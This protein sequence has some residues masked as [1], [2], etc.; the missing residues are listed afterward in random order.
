[1]ARTPSHSHALAQALPRS[2][3]FALLRPATKPQLDATRILTI[4][5]TLAINLIALGV[6]MMPLA[7]PTPA[8]WEEPAPR[9]PVRDIPK[10]K[11]VVVEIVEKAKPVPVVQPVRPQTV[12]PA[13]NP[14]NNVV[15]ISQTGSEQVVA[16]TVAEDIGPVTD[17]GSATSTAPTAVQ[18]EYLSAPPPKYPRGAL[19]RRIEGTVLLQVLVGIDGRP[20]DVTV[21]QTSGNRELDE[22]ARSQILKRWS[23]RPAMKNGQPVQALGLVP[24]A[25]NLAR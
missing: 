18:L 9:N 12:A 13:H 15:V 5:G 20:L 10:E 25:F 23:F 7:I 11:P 17:L 16:N 3:G 19:A 24:V 2:A 14:A 21:S 22:A 6:L 1:M 8:P 4:S